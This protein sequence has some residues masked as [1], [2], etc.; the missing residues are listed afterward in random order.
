VDAD[1]FRA[2]LERRPTLRA[3]MLAR[4]AAATA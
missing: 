1:Q 3:S 4:L 2:L